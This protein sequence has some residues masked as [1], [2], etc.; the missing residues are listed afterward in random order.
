MIK[1]LT[2]ENS[3]DTATTKILIVDDEM[4]ICYLLSGILRRKNF[5]TH[6]VNSLSD[7][8]AA[9]K[10][11]IP[12]L[13]FLDNHLPDGFG[14]DFIHFIKEHYPSIKVVMVTAHDTPGDRQQAFAEGADFFIGKPFTRD[15]I[16]LTVDKVMSA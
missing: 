7:A 11:E 13:V 15:I 9:L 3:A 12:S 2:M 14:M 10:K 1:I 8:E 5:T 6:Y 4:D 16:N